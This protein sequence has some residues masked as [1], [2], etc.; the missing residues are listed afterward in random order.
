MT[1]QHM[2]VMCQWGSPFLLLAEF[3]CSHSKNRAMV[4]LQ[5]HSTS[6]QP[7]GKKMISLKYVNYV[8]TR[9]QQNTLQLPT[10]MK[11]AVNSLVYPTQLIFEI[12][13]SCQPFL[14]ISQATLRLEDQPFEKSLPHSCSNWHHNVPE[15]CQHNGKSI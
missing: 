8:S 10:I 9:N 11:I 12:D 1:C 2:L 14:A 7:M 4:W 3:C 5:Q 6:V 15:K 13:F